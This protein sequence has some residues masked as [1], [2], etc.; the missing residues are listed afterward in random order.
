MYNDNAFGRAMVDKIISY[1][2]ILQLTS[3]LPSLNKPS[4]T[5]AHLCPFFLNLFFVHV[6]MWRGGGGGGGVTILWYDGHYWHF[7]VS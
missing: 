6:C 2:F 3:V 4:Y 7:S 5:K 1:H